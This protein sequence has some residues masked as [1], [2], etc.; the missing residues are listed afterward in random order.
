MDKIGNAVW[1]IYHSLYAGGPDIRAAPAP[2]SFTRPSFTRRNGVGLA[3]TLAIA[4]VTVA[5]TD[6][7]LYGVEVIITGILVRAILEL[8]SWLKRGRR[9]GTE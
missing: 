5:A 6:V 1:R 9:P 3:R 8:V 7:P 4:L 2:S